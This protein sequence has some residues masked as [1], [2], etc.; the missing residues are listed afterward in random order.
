[1]FVLQWPRGFAYYSLSFAQALNFYWPLSAQL[2]L[3][4]SKCSAF[5]F[6]Y[7]NIS[8]TSFCSCDLSAFL[9]CAFE[10]LANPHVCAI[11]ERAAL[12]SLLLRHLE[13]F[14]SL[15][16]HSS[17]AQMHEELCYSVL[18]GMLRRSCM[19]VVFSKMAREHAYPACRF[20]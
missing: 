8:D 6:V 11:R 2:L 14:D 9:Q 17:R 15:F 5:R 1:M 7:C 4:P 20:A 16:S 12:A 3:T 13:R 19:S 10:A 18:L